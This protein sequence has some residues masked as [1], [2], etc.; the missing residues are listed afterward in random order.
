MQLPVATDE[1]TL[2]ELGATLE[3][4]RLDELGATL[5]GVD[6]VVEPPH[7]PKSSQ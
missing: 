7:A 1:A 5:D 3:L 4:E 2:D 6:E